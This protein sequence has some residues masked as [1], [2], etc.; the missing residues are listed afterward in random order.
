MQ[1]ISAKPL[2][3]DSAVM[4]QDTTSANSPKP[5]RIG[6]NC[7]A[8]FLFNKD[9]KDPSKYDVEGAKG[10]QTSAQLQEYYMKL[11]QDHP[12]L[13]YLEDAFAEADVEGC[14]TFKR[15]LARKCPNVQMGVFFKSVEQM[16]A[17]TLWEPLDEEEAAQY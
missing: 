3:A 11:I 7:D 13:T 12:L 5:I 9:P 4:S 17:M 16:Q 2:S 14:R 8:D 1:L 15:A 10:V 6:V